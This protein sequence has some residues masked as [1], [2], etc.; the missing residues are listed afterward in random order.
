MAGPVYYSDLYKGE[1]KLPSYFDGKLFFY[2]WM[3]GWIKAISFFDDGT[4]NKM[5]PFVSDIE[6]NS[7]IDM[8]MGP[9]GRL[10][11]LEYGSGW[12][13]KNPDSGLSYIEYNGGNRPPVIDEFIVDRDSGPLPLKV[14]LKVGARDLEKDPVTYTWHLGDGTTKETSAPELSHEFL[15]EGEYEVSVAVKDPMGAYTES[16]IINIVAGNSRPEVSIALKSG[17]T[18]YYLPGRAIGYEVSVIDPDS[19]V[20]VDLNEVYVSVDY[21]TGLDEVQLSAGHKAFS[22]I[23]NGKALSLSLDCRACHK[24]MDASIGPSYFE[25]SEKYKDDP[26]AESYLQEK[27]ISGGA[28][29]WG[30]VAM[31]AHPDLSQS[32]SGMLSKY[33]LSLSKVGN[34]KNNSLPTSG[35]L[36]AK[37][38]NPNTVFQLSASYTDQGNGGAKPLTGYAAIRLKS[39]TLLFSEKITHEGLV[40]FNFNNTDLFLLPPKDSWFA[41]DNLD[42][43]GIGGAAMM[44]G[45]QHAPLSGLSF[46]IRLNSPDGPKIGS[47]NMSK[48]SENQQGGL[49]QFRFDRAYD[50]KDQL[51]YFIYKHDSETDRGENP[52]ALLNISFTGS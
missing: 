26:A 51:V 35:T 29:V 2:D 34:L 46:E 15:K 44:V 3:R 40:A 41:I 39:S 16:E 47:G 7:L 18:S 37:T 45:W 32:E 20:P 52:V 25:V 23:E 1:E 30:E 27:M 24:E 17:N 13:T 38:A 22:A 42:L 28:G 43:T 8:E 21:I 5:E 50:L 31:P 14:S 33:I 11:L 12:F 4:F 6:I 48:P 10:Y 9:D 49:V 19:K 36:I